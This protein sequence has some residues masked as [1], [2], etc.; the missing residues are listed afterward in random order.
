[1]LFVYTPEVLTLPIGPGAPL[2]GEAG[3]NTPRGPAASMS[4]RRRIAEALKRPTRTRNPRTETAA[5]DIASAAVADVMFDQLQYLSAH[6]VSGCP[7]G[8]ADCAR[9]AQ[10]KTLLLQPFLSDIRQRTPGQTASGQAGA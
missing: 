1:M 8:C 4:R 7:R 10:V 5:R 9:L 6:R 2:D 3:G